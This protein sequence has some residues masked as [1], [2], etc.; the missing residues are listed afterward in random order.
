[1]GQQG[2][3]QRAVQVAG[4]RVD[5]QPGRLVEHDQVGVLIQDG[6]RD[7][8]RLR[9]GRRRRRQMQR[10]GGAGAHRLGGLAQGGVALAGLAGL[11][12]RLDAGARQRADGI[13]Q[14]AVEPLARMAAS[15]GDAERV[16]GGVAAGDPGHRSFFRQL[17]QTVAAAASRGQSGGPRSSGSEEVVGNGM[18][19]LKVLTIV[20]GVMIVAGTGV[21]VAVIAHR[22]AS[23]APDVTVAPARRRRP[24]R[25]RWTSRPGRTSP[26]SPRWE[27]GWPCSCRA[28]AR[29]G[30]CW[31]IRAPARSRGGSPWRGEHA[32]L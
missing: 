17:D 5:D 2:V 9:R 13:G 25:W 18:R 7:R 8:L 24:S 12:Q 6:Q 3:D 26:A 10:V 1:M 21:L 4:R 29:T 22:V 11:D 23:P 19:A 15:G 27:T 28:A 16:G 31:W 14:E 20:M 32:A 30:W